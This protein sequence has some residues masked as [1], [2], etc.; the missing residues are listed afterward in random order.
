M[1]TMA[2]PAHIVD[3]FLAKGLRPVDAPTA[4]PRDALLRAVGGALRCHLPGLYDPSPADLR[5]T[6]ARTMNVSDGY[7]RY[8]RLRAKLDRKGYARYRNSVGRPKSYG[9]VAMLLAILDAHGLT[10]TLWVVPS[11][12]GKRPL[13][14]LVALPGGTGF[15]DPPGGGN[16]S[17][18]PVHCGGGTW[19][20]HT[21]THSMFVALWLFIRAC[22]MLYICGCLSDVQHTACCW[23]FIRAC[24]ILLC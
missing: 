6:A 21:G 13:Q 11:L 7:A 22:C 12:T 16:V 17:V 18:N 8:G 23:L 14:T 1:A 24:S 20:G 10:A 9:D 2:L 3:L 15:V 19:C 5:A 4:P